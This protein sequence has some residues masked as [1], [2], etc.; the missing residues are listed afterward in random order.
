MRSCFQYRFAGGFLFCLLQG[1]VFVFVFQLY[2]VLSSWVWSIVFELLVF[3]FSLSFWNK[4]SNWYFKKHPSDKGFIFYHIAL[5]FG[6]HF[7]FLGMELFVQNQFPS[8][9]W[10]Y[11]SLV[12]V[13]MSDANLLLIPVG[14]TCP[15]YSLPQKHEVFL[16][17]ASAKDISQGY[18]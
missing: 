6:W 4:F 3:L 12:P 7:F 8:E 5:P 1:F 15:A 16:S 14:L 10:R 13:K 11:F 18:N 2:F 17:L 9:P